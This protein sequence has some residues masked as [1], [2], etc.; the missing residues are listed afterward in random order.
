MAS[1][2][3]TPL[4]LI[5]PYAAAIG[6]TPIDDA[7]AFAQAQI[8]GQIRAQGVKHG[9]QISWVGA[10]ELGEVRRHAGAARGRQVLW[11]LALHAVYHM[12]DILALVLIPLHTCKSGF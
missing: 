5:G 6:F 7:V 3:C 8:F 11:I 10:E 1:S 9:L 2:R 12:Q 4:T